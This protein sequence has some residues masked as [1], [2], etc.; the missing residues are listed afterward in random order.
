MLKTKYKKVFLLTSPNNDFIISIMNAN[1]KPKLLLFS[2]SDAFFRNYNFVLTARKSI[3][4]FQHVLFLKGL[5][6]YKKFATYFNLN[7]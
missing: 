4:N 6:T 3:L 7:K 5:K 2:F 1:K